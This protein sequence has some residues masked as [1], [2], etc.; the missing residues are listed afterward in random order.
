MGECGIDFD[1]NPVTLKAPLFDAFSNE[2]VEKLA[3]PKSG[4]EGGCVYSDGSFALV[5]DGLL[6]GEATEFSFS[7]DGHEYRGRHTGILAYRSADENMATEGS[8]LWIDGEKAALCHQI[9][10]S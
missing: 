9:F 5:G 2:I 7:L 8:E 1:A 3:C 10:D 4:I 6:T